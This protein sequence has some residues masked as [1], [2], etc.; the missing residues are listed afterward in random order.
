M[1][2]RLFARVLAGVAKVFGITSLTAFAT[3]SILN[4]PSYAEDK[5]F[6]C[7]Q[8]NDVP[9]TFARTQEGRRMPV[10]YWGINSDFPPPWTPIRRCQEVSRRFQMNFDHGTLKFINA[11][12]ILRQPV[13]CGAI[14]KEDPCTDKTL[15][16]TLKPNSDPKSVLITL[17]DRRE[18][19]I[20]NLSVMTSDGVDS[21]VGSQLAVPSK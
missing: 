18:L 17:L 8:I 12:R 3:A 6:Y 9:V 5:S 19:G 7:D 21:S 2:L 10:I 14:R 20:R 4:Q 1:R 13:V 16:F 15:L 11:G